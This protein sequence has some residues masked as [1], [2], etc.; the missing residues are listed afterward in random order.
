MRQIFFARLVKKHDW[1]LIMRIKI[2]PK[3]YDII[4]IVVLSTRLYPYHYQY[5]IF[6][7]ILNRNHN[8]Q[9]SL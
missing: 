9:F 1:H 4:I 3:I 2:I 6:I 5:I 8:Y 7:I